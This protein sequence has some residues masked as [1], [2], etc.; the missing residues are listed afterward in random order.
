MTL[1]QFRILIVV[2]LA[3]ALTGGSQLANPKMYIGS[4]WFCA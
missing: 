4:S 3:V 2:F 1:N